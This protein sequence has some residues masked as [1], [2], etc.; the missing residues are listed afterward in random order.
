MLVVNKERNQEV[1]QFEPEH[2]KLEASK[3]STIDEVL[4]RC[5]ALEKVRACNVSVIRKLL[6][7]G[8]YDVNRGL[9]TIVDSLLEYLLGY[10]AV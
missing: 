7:E 9:N 10:P 2:K 5:K 4:E 1:I 6:A 8:Q 3:P